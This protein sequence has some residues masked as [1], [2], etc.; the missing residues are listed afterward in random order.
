MPSTPTPG[1]LPNPT[2]DLGTVE[3]R[4]RLFDASRGPDAPIAGATIRYDQIERFGPGVSGDV[5][6]DAAGRFAFTLALH[7][8][9]IVILRALPD[10]YFGVFAR[11]SGVDLWLL[12]GVIN[13]PAEPLGTREPV[14]I[15]GLVYD[16]SIGR[17]APIA[18]A[19][20]TY[21]SRS[22]YFPNESG[23]V[24][25]GADGRYQITLMLKR[26]D[27]TQSVTLAGSAAG[28]ASAGADPLSDDL[29]AEPPIDFGLVPGGG[30]IEVQPT[31]AYVDCEPGT[32]DVT[33]GNVGGPDDG[34][35]VITAI[36]LSHGYSQGDYGRAFTWDLSEITLPAYLASGEQLSFPVTFPGAGPGGTVNSRLH[37]SVISGASN[38]EAGS[39]VYRGR[40]VGCGVPTPTPTPTLT[41]VCAGDC[42][43]DGTVGIG[44]LVRGVA[45]A[46][47]VLDCSECGVAFCTATCGPGPVACRPQ[48]DCLVRATRSVLD[49]C[50]VDAC[51]TDADCDDG[52]GC[53]ADHCT[54]SGCV[55]E[56]LCV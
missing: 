54:P 27:G 10:G 12:A 3:I 30:I 19:E 26:G 18:G 7:D 44:E 55:S 11:Y 51:R 16:L 32:I 56:C 46:L 8:T 35:L 31:Q 13:L 40:S 34:T 50:R 39:G 9:D 5:T 2:G 20:V 52:N 53:S 23:T 21:E 1:P 37:L 15:G 48:I 49:G 38:R 29:F 22:A 42:N 45:M 33:I 6:T 41:G 4:G 14:D 17:S 43:G 36:N 25:A 28:F 24:Q 47:G